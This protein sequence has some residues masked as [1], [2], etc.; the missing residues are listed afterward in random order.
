MEDDGGKLIDNDSNIKLIPR[1]FLK[2]QPPD[3]L[4]LLEYINISWI[5]SVLFVSAP[6]R[7]SFGFLYI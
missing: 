4:G 7:A 5:T 6:K 3:K 2:D 1:I